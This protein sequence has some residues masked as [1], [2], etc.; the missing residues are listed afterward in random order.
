M[1][2][3]ISTGIDIEEIDRLRKI[4]PEIRSR[5]VERILTTTEIRQDRL[6]EETIIGVFCAKEA[7]S[8]ALGSGIGIITWHEIEILKDGNS[9]PSVI[10]TG[11][12]L[13]IANSKNIK[14][15]SVSISHTRQYA[16]AVAVG[17]GEI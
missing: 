17:Y 7:V 6:T 8:K 11:K 9:A 1:S 10:L 3:V 2:V 16:A 13:A 12:A 4:S 5:F 15:W 14:S